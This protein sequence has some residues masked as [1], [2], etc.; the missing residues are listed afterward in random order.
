MPYRLDAGTQGATTGWRVSFRTLDDHSAIGPGPVA[1][2]MP[3]GMPSV[4]D[5]LGAWIL[6]CGIQRHGPIV[7]RPRTPKVGQILAQ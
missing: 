4:P 5:P 1:S 3:S 7:L 2:P 6:E